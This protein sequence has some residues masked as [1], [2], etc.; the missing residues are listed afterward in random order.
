MIPDRQYWPLRAPS[1]RRAEQVE[2]PA[3]KGVE[4]RTTVWRVGYSPDP[5]AWSGWQWATDG[6]FSGRFDDVNG[7]FRT[8]YAGSSLLACL[9]EVL[10]PFRADAQVVSSLKDIDDDDYGETFPTTV[11][12]NVPA[13]WLHCRTT[14]SARLAGTYCAVTSSESV[15]VLYPVF[16]P[17]ALTLGLRDFDAAALKDR[18]YRPLTQAVAA[19]VHD[20][21]DF[22][23]VAFTSRHGDDLQLW[24]IFEQPEDPPVSPKLIGITN[25]DLRAESLEMLEAFTILGLSWASPGH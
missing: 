2:S 23:G 9:L 20:A 10:A 12:G 3:L 22:D 4:C 6:T 13:D 17:L 8:V 1:P 21:T 14:S 7:N 18:R 16:V 24:A 5:W 15:A 25:Y 11:A 19:Y